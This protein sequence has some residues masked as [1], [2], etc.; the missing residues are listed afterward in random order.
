MKKVLL[1]VFTPLLVITS[2]EKAVPFTPEV[3]IDEIN[4][5]TIH[6]EMV[7]NF[8]NAEEYD[9]KNLPRE[10]D[11]KTNLGNN[12]PINISWESNYKEE[13]EYHL[14]FNDNTQELNYFTS[15]TSFDF[16]NYKLNTTYNLHIEVDDYRSENI[17]FTTPGGFTRTINVEGVSN[18]RD[19]GDGV[20]IKQGLIYRSMTFENN[21]I[22]GSEFTD[23]TE[24]GIKEIK[25]LGIKS[26]L[27]LRKDEE[28]GENFGKIEGI[29]YQFFP[30]YYGGQNVLIYKN[31]EFDN[32]AMC[33]QIFAF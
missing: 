4:E 13:V 19:L 32:A 29:N 3:K 1:F 23:I 30:L 27:D 24:S 22:A 31:S 2:C 26:E 33:R 15:E 11:A 17:S 9:A 16:Y 18:F 5:I 12:L 21:T 8:F 6:S 7:T 28:R 25:N 10:A 20:K 14:V